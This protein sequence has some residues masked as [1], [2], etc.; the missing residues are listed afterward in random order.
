M[1]DSSVDRSS[2]VS[3]FEWKYSLILSRRT[4]WSSFSSSLQTFIL[5]GFGQKFK[6]LESNDD[7]AEFRGLLERLTT[8]LDFLFSGFVFL[9]KRRVRVFLTTVSSVE[10]IGV[11]GLIPSFLNFGYIYPCFYCLCQPFSVPRN[12]C[13]LCFVHYIAHSSS[14][15]GFWLPLWYLQTF[16]YFIDILPG[17]IPFCSAIKPSSPLTS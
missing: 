10:S 8:T 15:Y 11:L 3:F 7:S 6:P 16:W 14:M 13:P 2:L 4:N 5:G 9:L 1:S 12:V 17:F